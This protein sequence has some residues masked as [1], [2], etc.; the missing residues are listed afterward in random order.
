MECCTVHVYNYRLVRS[1]LFR[2]KIE[3]DYGNGGQLGA[4]ILLDDE[5]LE[6]YY[7]MGSIQVLI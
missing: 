7:I 1:V 4:I 5:I 2:G 3:A 6:S